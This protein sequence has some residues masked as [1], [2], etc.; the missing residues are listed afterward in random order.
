MSSTI[1]RVFTVGDAASTQS[2][3]H[4]LTGRV[5]AVDPDL[6]VLLIEARPGYTAGAWFHPNELIHGQRY[7]GCGDAIR[8]ARERAG[9][10]QQELSAR[11]GINQKMLSHY[12]I[13]RGAIADRQATHVARA[14]GITV[15]ELLYGAVEQAAD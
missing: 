10:T 8:A 15:D 1:A 4:S 5:H 6:G 9:L 11:T 7:H 2:A 12:E 14:L 13:N 3:N